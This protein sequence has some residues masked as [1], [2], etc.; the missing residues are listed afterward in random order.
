MTKAPAPMIG[1]ISCPP[2]DA[3][4]S[5]PAANWGRNPFA[6]IRGMVIT[7]V[8]AV[9]AMADP[10]MVPV[11]ADDNTA[12]KAAPPLIRPATSLDNSMTKSLAPDT[13]K[14]PPKIINNVILVDEIEASMQ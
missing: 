8:D 5:T 1:G 11:S 7:P 6:F 3:A 10:E 13:T 12:T 14:K 2:V 4:A 9:F